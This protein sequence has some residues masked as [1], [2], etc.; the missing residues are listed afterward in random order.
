[1]YKGPIL[2]QPL[3]MMG[4]GVF[5]VRPSKKKLLV[6]SPRLHPFALPHGFSFLCCIFKPF[7][8]FPLGILVYYGHFAPFGIVRLPFGNFVNS[9]LLF[10]TS[11]PLFAPYCYFGAILHKKLFV[12]FNIFTFYE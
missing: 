9:R 5:S 4:G 11:R 3:Y 10:G 8:E 12:Y 7:E 6:S 2:L 1:M